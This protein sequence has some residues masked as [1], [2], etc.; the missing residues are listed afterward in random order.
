MILEPEMIRE[1]VQYLI[2]FIKHLFSNFMRIHPLAA[3]HKTRGFEQFSIE[4]SDMLSEHQLHRWVPV[5]KIIES[6]PSSLILLYVTITLGWSRRT[7]LLY[8][9][10]LFLIRGLAILGCLVRCIFL[11]LS[12]GGIFMLEFYRFWGCL[13]NSSLICQ[14]KTSLRIITAIYRKSI[15]VHIKAWLDGKLFF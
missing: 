3:N 14:I 8:I 12:A 6:Y 11:R 7:C 10:D 15:L 5:H 4:L 2:E 1:V 13:L 9:K